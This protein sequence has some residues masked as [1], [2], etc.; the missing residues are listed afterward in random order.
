MKGGSFVTLTEP[1]IHRKDFLVCGS[2]RV[3]G[4]VATLQGCL[5]SC[6]MKRLL[7]PGQIFI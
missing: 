3:G 7:S 2:G 6:W 1:I 4:H 5:L